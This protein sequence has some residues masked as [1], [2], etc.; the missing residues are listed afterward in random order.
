MGIWLSFEVSFPLSLPLKDVGQKESPFPRAE[1]KWQSSQVPSGTQPTLNLS[2]GSQEKR[3]SE[4]RDS[5]K[6][7]V[8]KAAGVFR[9]LPSAGLT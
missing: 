8:W 3:G 1:L 9:C 6:S 2:L 5:A 7:V 4:T